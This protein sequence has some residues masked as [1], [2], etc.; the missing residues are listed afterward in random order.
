GSFGHHDGRAH[1]VDP[2]PDKFLFH[3]VV[4]FHAVAF[5][6]HLLWFSVRARHLHLAGHIHFDKTSVH[7]RSAGGGAFRF[8]WLFAGIAI[9]PH[10]DDVV[11][12]A[13]AAGEQFVVLVQLRHLHHLLHHLLHVG[14]A[15]LPSRR[16]RSG[17]ICRHRHRAAVRNFAAGSRRRLS[18]R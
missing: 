5:E 17:W 13:V 16:G 7:D 10:L 9:H 3:I 14:S 12:S 18:K 15:R 4:S 2:S 11:P 1:V 8:L 6:C